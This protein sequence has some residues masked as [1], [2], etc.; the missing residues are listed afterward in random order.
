M[1]RHSSI[2]DLAQAVLDSVAEEPVVK[3]ASEVEP[4]AK[5]EI[6]DALKKAAEHLRDANVDEVT[7]EDLASAVKTA[8]V[9]VDVPA[10][11]SFIRGSQLGGELR[12][13]AHSLRETGG[14]IA[15]A[16]ATK[17]AQ[18]LTAAVGLAHLTEGVK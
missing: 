8:A 16:K 12:K 5:T 4:S 6:G 10:L 13:I 2:S 3:T 14:E 1:L 11:D 18:M 7:N 17:V 15:D 9:T